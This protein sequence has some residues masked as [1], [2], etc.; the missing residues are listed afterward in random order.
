MARHCCGNGRSNCSART[1]GPTS[2]VTAWKTGRHSCRWAWRRAHDRAVLFKSGATGEVAVR[3]QTGQPFYGKGVLHHILAD[4]VSRFMPYMRVPRTARRRQTTTLCHNIADCRFF[5]FAPL[6]I[7]RRSIR[8]FQLGKLLERQASRL[9]TRAAQRRRAVEEREKK[10]LRLSCGGE[11]SGRGA[12][13]GQLRFARACAAA[14]AHASDEARRRR[15]LSYRST[16]CRC[17]C[18]AEAARGKSGVFFPRAMSALRHGRASAS[19]AASKLH[20]SPVRSASRGS[21]PYDE[22]DRSRCAGARLGL[23]SLRRPVP[24]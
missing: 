21:A 13:S 19:A 12:S 14:C 6:I 20:R 2:F 15:V 17:D 3:D 9:L 23:C 18:A 7:A 24:D 22:S 4:R 8:C 1:N 5:S 11:E 16:P 10:Y